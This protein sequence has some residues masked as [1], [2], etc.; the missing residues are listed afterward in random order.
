[1]ALKV[2]F[3]QAHEIMLA[4]PEYVLLDVRD[5]VEYITGHADNSELLP[6]ADIDDYSAAQIIPDYDTPVL[7][8]CRTGQ[9]SAAAAEKLEELGYTHVYN[10]GSMVGWPYGTDTT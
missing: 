6:L 3:E 8:Y 7:T 1:M 4:H 10:I 2:N 5:E 9:R